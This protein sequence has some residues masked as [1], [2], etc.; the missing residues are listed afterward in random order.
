MRER[1]LF[2]LLLFGVVFL[3]WA[4]PLNLLFNGTPLVIW[5]Q[6]L[7]LI[8]SYAA[9]RWL[10]KESYTEGFR[11]LR[12]FWNSFLWVLFCISC[13]TIMSILGEGL[14]VKR[15]LYAIIAYI[16]FAPYAILPVIAHKYGKLQG[17]LRLISLVSI[18]CAIGLILDYFFNLSAF[19]YMSLGAD[20]GGGTLERYD[21]ALTRAAFPFESPSTGYGFLS[22]G[23]LFTYL[24]YGEATTV[25]ERFI[26]LC[27]VL[28]ILLGGLLTAT[29]SIWLLFG[30][31][32]IAIIV[33]EATKGLR[34][35]NLTLLIFLV[36]VTIILIK[37]F[38]SKL[39]QADVLLERARTAVSESGE[40]NSHR[41]N[42][43]R[44]GLELI[45]SFNT[46]TFLGH[47][48]GTTMGQV[49]DGFNAHT[50]YESSFFQSFYEGG[51]VGLLVRYFGYVAA[52]ISLLK[53]GTGNLRVNK[54]VRLEDQ[55]IKQS[56]KN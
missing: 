39:D 43:W 23:F 25:R 3:P 44:Q 51:I 12:V 20:P 15:C 19:T 34:F 32:L 13:W 10:V 21:F 5:K 47:G 38:S 28:I 42:R 35:K 6:A 16:G 37:P 52:L 8:L 11:G 50:H 55:C 24:L 45:T 2:A 54:L 26:W 40:A 29:R 17:L 4:L 14:S 41:Y 1:R 27:G 18:S 56:V 46:E 33:S 9:I 49:N 31:W 53:G 30:I 48:L 22:L 7:A 36:S